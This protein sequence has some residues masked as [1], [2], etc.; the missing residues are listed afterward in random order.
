AATAEAAR[1][2]GALLHIHLS[3]TV[4][5]DVALRAEHGGSVTSLLSRLGVLGG[6]VLAAHGV[7]LD[8][9]DIALL[10]RHGAAVAHCPG[11]NAKLAAGIA[12]VAAL[13]AAAVPLALGT[14]GPASVD[15]LDLWAQARL[16]CYITRLAT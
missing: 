4:G 8:A 10:A 6:R 9:S 16:A 15:D 1:E 12:P 2:R 11:S 14:D 3:E 13:R 7:H 5:E